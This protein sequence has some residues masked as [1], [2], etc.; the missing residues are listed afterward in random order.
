MAWVSQV[1]DVSPGCRSDSGDAAPVLL[2]DRYVSAAFRI[3]I[4]R[5][6]IASLVVFSIAVMGVGSRSQSC[7]CE[8][9]RTQSLSLDN[10]RPELRIGIQRPRP[11]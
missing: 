6:A 7:Y 3:W 4:C 11:E 9:L 10:W 8:L 1:R 5:C 2:F